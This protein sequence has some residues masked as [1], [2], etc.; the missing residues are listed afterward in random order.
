MRNAILLADTQAAGGDRAA[1]WD[2]FA[3]RG[4]GYAASTAG[5]DDVGPVEDYSAAAGG[6]PQGAVVGTVRDG[7]TGVPLPNALVGFAGH[8]SGLGEDLSDRT[9]ADGSYRI[10]HVPARTWDF[11]SVAAGAGY[12][13]ELTDDVAVGTGTTTLDF[14]PRRNWALASGG[15]QIPSFTGPDLTSLAAARPG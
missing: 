2:V 12:D 6:D 7:D 13:R 14:G 11:A 5:T 9:A 10:E 8:D 3:A 15:A 1:I 4:M